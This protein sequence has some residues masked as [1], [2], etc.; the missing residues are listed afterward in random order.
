MAKKPVDRP[1]SLV[2]SR[3][4]AKELFGHLF[5]GD[6]DEHGAVIGVSLARSARG[7]RLLARRLYLARDG[8]DYVPGK[9][10]Y[11][12]LTPAFVRDRVLDCHREGL[13]YLA[14]HCHSGLD[15][16]S[17]SSDDLASHRRGYPALNQ[18][19]AGKIVGGL[20]FAQRSVAGDLWISPSEQSPLAFARVVDH[21]VV[22]L[23]ARARTTE[24]HIDQEMYD[25]QTRVFGVG[26]QLILADQRVGVIG[27]GGAGS[28][29]IEYLAHLGV[30]TIVTAD[31][32]RLE[33]SNQPRVVGSRRWHAMPLLT[34]PRRPTWARSLGDRLAVPKVRISHQLAR[35]INAKVSFEA[36]LGDVTDPE[37]ARRFADCDYLFLAADSHQARHVF[38]SIV[39]QFLVPGCQVGA[40]VSTDARGAITTVFSVVRPVTPDLGCLWCNGLVSPSRLAEE[41]QS[42][43]ERKRHRYVDDPGVVSPSVITL[44]A[45]A[46]SHAVDNYLYTVTGLMPQDGEFRWTYYYPTASV[47]TT[48]VEQQIPRKS[49]ECLECGMSAGSRFAGGDAKR[50]P[51]KASG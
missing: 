44:N 20:V 2:L 14:V 13:G 6:D 5:P 29:I 27:A 41:A 47:A 1:W 23:Y 12:M 45:V 30:G 3:S 18:I 25:R 7:N 4:I 49:P 51:T 17:F 39:H 36:L 46:A 8:I 40:K 48:R 11:R 35:R 9:H 38:N 31:P 34:D 37:I 43:E 26:G 19:L 15:E 24:R 42:P 32:D 28:L 21:P 10:G 22:T 33:A 50:L 16:V